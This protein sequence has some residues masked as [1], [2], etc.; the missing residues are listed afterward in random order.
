MM[1]LVPLLAALL[2]VGTAGQARAA[3]A[4][5]GTVWGGTIKSSLVVPAGTYCDLYGVVVKGG[6]TVEPGGYLY[7]EGSDI[8]GSVSGADVGYVW[9]VLGVVRGDIS[10]S[11]VPQDSV[12]L[13]AMEIRGNV[14]LTGAA[15]YALLRDSN[16]RGNVT[17]NDNAFIYVVNTTVRG[18]LACQ[19]NGGVDNDGMP[20][21][22]RGA[23]SG[24]C[25]GL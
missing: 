25:V 16:V 23:S 12:D 22:V 17:M 10:V 7:T 13:S 19:G 5:T 6:V 2:T 9:L 21:N 20:N 4:C 24:D 15:S 18:N 3:A 14:V 11:G 1:L 8:R